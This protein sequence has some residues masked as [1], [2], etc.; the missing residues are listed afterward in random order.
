MSSP[1]VRVGILVFVALIAFL[2]VA[3]FLTGYRLRKDG[4][5][6]NVTFEDAMGI[7][8]GTEVRMAGVAIGRVES[9]TLNERQNA[10][11]KLLIN[12]DFA[13]PKGSRFL[14]RVGMLI[15][16]KFID[17][18]PKREAKTSLKE[19]VN[20]VGE[21]PAR[22]EDLIPK[23][24]KV[25]DNL[26]EASE[27]INK[28]LGSEDIGNSL[29]S[30]LANLDSATARLD[31]TMAAIQGTVDSQQDDFV[32]VIRDVSVSSKNLRDLTNEIAAYVKS[33]TV[34][35]NITG[36]LE[37][38]RMTA[39]ALDRSIASLERSAG[40]MERSTGSI[41]RTTTSVEN[42]VTST[43]L[44]DDIRATVKEARGTVNEARKSVDHI[45]G[46]LGV[47]KPRTGKKPGLIPK[48]DIRTPSLETLFVS[49]ESRLRA[50]AHATV[51]LKDDNFVR[52][53]VY[54]FGGLNKIIIQPGKSLNKRTDVRYGLY[55]SKLSIG[56]DH[57]F[58]EKILG[59]ANLYDA[60]L[61]R[62]DVQGSY[63]IT[64]NWGL[65]FGVDSLLRDNKLTIGARFTQ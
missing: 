10:V 22:P 44:Q 32:A 60:S 8:N 19:G 61:M 65:M 9:V 57:Q 13:I 56:M 63:K 7:T 29:D 27:N 16:D 31:K 36:T 28:V 62:L 58:S 3:S 6:V 39:D 40:S 30:I 17:V 11:M 49:D 12:R 18:L 38:V 1:G 5:D 15:G 37:S 25:M 21:V 51:G 23:A 47:D 14:I 41:E 48:I 53:G 43:E 52:L 2:A 35:E 59:S 46:I 4:Y 20:I 64:D 55:A 45:N 34:Q 50:T 54:D 33:G 26:T 24:Q 42:L